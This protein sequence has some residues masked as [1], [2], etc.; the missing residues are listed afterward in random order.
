M[1]W[2][3]VLAWLTK[4]GYE[5]IVCSCDFA[6]LCRKAAAARIE[7]LSIALNNGQAIRNILERVIGFV[8]VNKIVC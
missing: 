8:E 7:K 2:R 6:T 1:R 5:G 4:K 3:S